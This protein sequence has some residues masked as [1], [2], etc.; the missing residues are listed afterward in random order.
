[1]LKSKINTET[2]K[3]AV[4]K[5]KPVIWTIAI[6]RLRIPYFKNILSN[7]LS[8]YRKCYSCQHILLRLIETWRKCLDEN[9]LVGAILMDLSKAFDCLP[10]DL[11]IAKLEAYGVTNDALKLILSYLSQSKQC[12]KNG[13]SLSLLK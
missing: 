13:G 5:R 12:V 6:R 2:G 4:F 9:R 10:H 8:A 7:F 3:I 1:M 11:L